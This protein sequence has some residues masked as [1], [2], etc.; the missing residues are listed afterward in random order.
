MPKTT[1]IERSSN[2]VSSII[3]NSAA[4]RQETLQARDMVEIGYMK[5]AKCLYD[6]YT[7]NIY[8]TWDFP[9]FENYVDSEL[10]FNYR[11]AMYLVEIY[12]KALLLNMDME[13]LERIG[14]TKAK[15]LIRVV[16]QNNADEWMDVAEKSTTKELNFK[17]KTEKESQLDHTSI[18]EEVPTVTTITFK[19]GM[20]EKTLVSEAL[21]ESARLI[22]SDDFALA[23][24]NIASEWLE[25]KGVVPL[26]TTLEDHIEHLERIYGRKLIVSGPIIVEDENDEEDDEEPVAKS[27][28]DT[29]EFEELF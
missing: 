23:L 8:Q 20:A 16:D 3:A 25:M 5:L 1:L 6:I 10:Q 11:K 21:E 2:E 12:N 13:R 14:W 22:N 27:K 26:Q 17:I 4:I 15:E 18:V 9:N 24:A 7:Q 19:L 28:E 29:D